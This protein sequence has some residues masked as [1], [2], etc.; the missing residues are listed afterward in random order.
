MVYNLKNMFGKRS[1]TFL[2][3]LSL[4]SSTFYLPVFAPKTQAVFGVLDTVIDIKA[5][6]RMIVDGIAMSLAQ[7]MIDDMVKSTIDWAN[8]GFEG[9]PAYVTDPKR[10][11]ADI[12]DGVAGEF[13]AGSDLNFLC[14]PFRTQVR[15]SLLKHYAGPSQPF[16]CTFTGVLE[17]FYDD[18]NQGGWD[19]W[20]SMTQN[21]TNNPYDSYLDAQIELEGRLAEAL[22]LEKDQLDRNQGF[23]SWRECIKENPAVDAPGHV[24]GKAV[25]ECIERGPVKTPGT[26]IKAQLDQVLPSGLAKLITVNHVEQLISAFATGLL[27]KFVFGPEGLFTSAGSGGPLPEGNRPIDIDGDGTVDGIDTNGDGRPDIC[28]FGG[29]ST[30]TGPP[31]MGSVEAEQGFLPPPS[32]L[33]P[34]TLPPSLPPLLPGLL[35]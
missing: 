11:F 10:F 34:P 32:T 24:P 1:V 35:P 17:N 29:T 21:S 12:A 20:F 8:D 22:G 4:V 27:T 30:L 2:L 23:L 14:S 15:L 9:N 6:A 7:R 13:I 31:C 18:F 16:Q 25:G 33:P 26:T 3:I 19:A 28:Y 5:L